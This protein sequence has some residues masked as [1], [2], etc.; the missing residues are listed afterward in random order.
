MT[1]EYGIVAFFMGMGAILIGALIL[2]YSKKRNL[3]Y[4]VWTVKLG[5]AKQTLRKTAPLDFKVAHLK[6]QNSPL[7]I[8]IRGAILEFRA[9]WPEEDKKTVTPVNQTFAG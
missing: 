5:A 8:E 7:D 9:Q 1:I 2:K 4:T 6:L 3:K